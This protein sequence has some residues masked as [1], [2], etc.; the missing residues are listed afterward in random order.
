MGTVTGPS[1][2]QAVLSDSSVWIALA[3]YAGE[4]NHGYFTGLLLLG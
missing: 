4:R 1:S 2:A 3:G